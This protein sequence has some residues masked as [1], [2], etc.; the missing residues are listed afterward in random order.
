MSAVRVLAAAAAVLLAALLQVSVLSQVAWHGV[1][2]NLVLLV[3]VAAGLVRGASF[4]MVLGL[5]A[6]LLLDLAP[7]ADHVAGRWALALVLVG[8]VAGQVNRE[9]RGSA[10]AVV[11]TVAVCSLLGTT[12]FAL[13]GALLGDP[14]TSVG[15]VLGVVGLALLLDVVLTPLV[16]PPLMAMFRRLEP[17]RGLAWQR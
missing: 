12:V 15:S 7:P 13:T 5:A 2:P 6:G 14:I 10:G 3:V 1:V 8:L 17:A 11:A 9:A 16:L 4:A